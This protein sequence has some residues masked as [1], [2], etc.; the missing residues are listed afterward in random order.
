MEQTRWIKFGQ[1]RSGRPENSKA[2]TRSFLFLLFKSSSTPSPPPN[3]TLQDMLS[4]PPEDAG[5]RS[6]PRYRLQTTIDHDVSTVFTECDVRPIDARIVLKDFLRGGK[7]PYSHCL[8]TRVR[9][10]TR[11][12]WREHLPACVRPGLS[13]RPTPVPRGRP[14]SRPCVRCPANSTLATLPE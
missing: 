5:G 2:F 12:I 3:L 7:I 10:H 6:L 4:V 1:K 11:P 9:G 14:S 13:A 8:V